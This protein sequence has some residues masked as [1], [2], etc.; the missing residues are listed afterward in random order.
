MVSKCLQVIYLPESHTGVAICNAI[1]ATLDQWSVCEK[2]IAVTT[3]NGSNMIKA[4]SE[5]HLPRIP[6]IGH[7][8]NNA[9]N[10]AIKGDERIGDLLTLCRKASA[11]FSHS[12]N[13]KQRLVEVQKHLKLPMHSLVGDVATR[14]GSKYHMLQRYFEQRK[15]VRELFADG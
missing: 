2:V 10:N 15:A 14:W 4:V 12:H 5:M 13:M 3:D 8:L 1:M 9:V 11:V 6:C 7:V